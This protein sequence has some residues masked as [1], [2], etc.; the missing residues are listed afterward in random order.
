MYE[1]VYICYMYKYELVYMYIYTYFF[2]LFLYVYCMSARM[3][4]AAVASVKSFS[5]VHTSKRAT[6][7]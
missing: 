3:R 1:G 5:I 7:V 6:T 4:E 2:Y